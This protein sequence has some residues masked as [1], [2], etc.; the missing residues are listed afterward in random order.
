MEMFYLNVE[1][2]N[3]HRDRPLVSPHLSLWC[4]LLQY[5][6]LMENIKYELKNNWCH[7]Y[8]MSFFHYV[9]ESMLCFPLGIL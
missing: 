1:A 8:L 7:I 6:I 3:T 4:S 2:V 5:E 9:F